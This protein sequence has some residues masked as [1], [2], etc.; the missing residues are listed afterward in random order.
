[1]T[2]PDSVLRSQLELR[3]SAPGFRTLGGGAGGSGSLAQR[4]KASIA[5]TSELKNAIALAG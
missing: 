1:L 5:L 3:R 2:K 4:F